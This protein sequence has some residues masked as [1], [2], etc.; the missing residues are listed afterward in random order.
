MCVCMC[1]CV[2]VCVCVCKVEFIDEPDI[3]TFGIF[4][5][6]HYFFFKS[7]S[8]LVAFELK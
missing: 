4:D 8:I 5:N 3:S 2:C 6:L 1:V 7:S